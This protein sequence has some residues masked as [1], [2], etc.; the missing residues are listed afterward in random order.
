MMQSLNTAATGM[1]AQQT[2]LDVISNNLANV[3]T[4]GFKTAHAQFQDLMYQTTSA[5]SIASS[6]TAA[7]PGMTQ[8]GLGSKFAATESNFSEG[9]LNATGQWSDLAVNGQGF[10]RVLLPNGSYGYTRDG[11]FSVD[12]TGLLVSSSGYPL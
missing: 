1:I 11:S 12:S 8:V 7:R 10:F 3:N 5:A 6:G 4:T 9:A 2:N